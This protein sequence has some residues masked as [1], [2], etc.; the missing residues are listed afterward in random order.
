MTAFRT[1]SVVSR[2]GTVIG[3]R[4]LGSGPAVLLVH[5]GGQAAQNLMRLAEAPAGTFTAYVPDRRGRG[6]SGLAGA[7]Y[8]LA[9][10]CEDIAALVGHSGAERVFA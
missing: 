6:L 8:G 2:D 7:G 5:G 1:G 3:Y 9:A 10:E 4:E